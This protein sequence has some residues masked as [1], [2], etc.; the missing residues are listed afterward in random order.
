MNLYL[1]SFGGFLHAV[2]YLYE[3]CMFLDT[4]YGLFILFNGGFSLVRV[5][6]VSYFMLEWCSLSVI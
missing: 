5:D 6:H 4:Y 3:V 1:F 2:Q